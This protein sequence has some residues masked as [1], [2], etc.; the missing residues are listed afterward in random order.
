MNQP[1]TPLRK[2]RTLII[3]LVVVIVVLGVAFIILGDRLGR[4]TG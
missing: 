3:G 2:Y 1:S 4:H